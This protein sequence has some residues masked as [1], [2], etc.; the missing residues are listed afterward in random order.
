MARFKRAFVRKQ[1]RA[2][3]G[4]NNF[5]KQLEESFQQIV[6]STDRVNTVL[7]F[8]SALKSRAIW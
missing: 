8:M 6:E 4:R 7:T 5:K 3:L 2:T 1:D